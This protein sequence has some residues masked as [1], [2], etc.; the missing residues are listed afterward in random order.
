MP[1]L[2]IFSKRQKH[3]RIG[4]PNVSGQSDVESSPSSQSETLLSLPPPRLVSSP[5]ASSSKTRLPF[6]KKSPSTS[7]ELSYDST[8]LS[9]A[10]QT[11][12]PPRL[13]DDSS[14]PGSTVL[15]PPLKIFNL[16]NNSQDATSSPSM[17][18]AEPSP[19]PQEG[20]P[21]RH[22]TSPPP[23][24][25]TR[26]SPPKRIHGAGLFS[27]PRNLDKLAHKSS[28][29]LPKSQKSKAKPSQRDSFNLKSFRHVGGYHFDGRIS[30]QPT[31]PD[32]L[33]SSPSFTSS[34][35]P[36]RSSVSA[37]PPD[38][39]QRIPV[40]AFRE[41]QARRSAANS[42][43]TP[44]PPEPASSKHGHEQ[45]LG[46]S[47]RVNLPKPEPSLSSSETSSEQ[48]DSVESSEEPGNSPLRRKATITQRGLVG[49]GG[50]KSEGHGTVSRPTHTLRQRSN[51]THEISG[52]LTSPA[53]SP[54]S[55]YAAARG[56]TP[57]PTT[58]SAAASSDLYLRS[59]SSLSTSAV[60][61]SPD[62]NKAN[63][64]AA[65]SSAGES[66]KS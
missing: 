63:P 9:S 52:I 53:L 4:E 45:P 44:V 33:P 58:P 54:G 19:T 10:A 20:N 35:A 57:S 23:P 56:I 28:S 24:E 6:N 13:S 66:Y 65:G 31:L 18:T 39:T 22:A 36:L 16:Y 46:P 12:L 29:D 15:R 30:P 25:S 59:R 1:L 42:P 14:G 7:G 17:T 2:G 61:V 49:R 64:I 27:W 60:H 50:P 51:S 5:G 40:A 55:G 37:D 38:P 32:P 62:A 21:P 3:S 43:V 48:S 41:A 8:E 11:Q 34:P 47:S 26:R